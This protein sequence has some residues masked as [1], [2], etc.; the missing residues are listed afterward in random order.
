MKDYASRTS[1]ISRS[2]FRVRLRWIFLSFLLI[3]LVVFYVFHHKRIEKVSAGSVVTDKALSAV[4]KLPVKKNK[5]VVKSGMNFDFY[6]MLPKM[7]VPGGE[8]YSAADL[9]TRHIIYI[10]SSK[11]LDGTKAL[12]QRLALLGIAA[13][14]SAYNKD[15]KRWYRLLSGP[16]KALNQAKFD[17]NR[18]HQIGIPAIMSN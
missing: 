7:N 13:K 17:L 14:I 15:D 16:Y 9:G 3:T 5:V 10:S 8:G 18:L 2:S 4:K 11:S 1:S 6:T 12:Q